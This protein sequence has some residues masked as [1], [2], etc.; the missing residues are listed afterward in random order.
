MS[1]SD[2]RHPR[3]FISYSWDDPEHKQ[4]VKDL[5]GSL[6]ADGVDVKLD[7]W[8]LAPGDDLPAFMEQSVRE[9]DFVLIVCTPKYKDRA[10]HRKGGAG[11]EGSIMTAEIYQGAERR[12]FIPILRGSDWKLSA[13]SWLQGSIRIDLRGSP[14]SIEEYRVLL[15]ALHNLREGAPPIGSPPIKSSNPVLKPKD[16]TL[17]KTADEL[18]LSVESYRFFTER[19]K[20]WEHLLFYQVLADETARF[21]DIRRDYRLGM[22]KGNVKHLE[23]K[24]VLSKVKLNFQEMSNLAEGLAKIINTAY[25]EA[26]G[27]PGTSADGESVVYVARKLAEVYRQAIES[28]LRWRSYIVPSECKRLIQL[29]EKTPIRFIEGIEKFISEI[30]QNLDS[31]PTLLASGQ[32]VSFKSTL[33]VGFPDGLL[34]QILYEYKLVS[35]TFSQD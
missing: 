14:H 27:P 6:R 5:A 13:P 22:Q 26:M 28:G 34:D 24:S 20:F 7:H 32:E 2:Q 30:K 10:D 9:S 31:I 12:K 18:R 25:P 23:V 4:W 33:E 8:E 11:Y 21:K 29:A 3:A 15:E 17:L 35:E 1:T 16:P 19:P